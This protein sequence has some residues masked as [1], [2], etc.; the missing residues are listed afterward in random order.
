MKKR[1]VRSLQ[2]LTRE[3]LLDVRKKTREK[4][5]YRA[6]AVAPHQTLVSMAIDTYWTGQDRLSDRAS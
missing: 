2:I 6:L 5:L 1:K 4:R 3:E